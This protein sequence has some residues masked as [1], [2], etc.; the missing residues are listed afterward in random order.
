MNKKPACFNSFLPRNVNKTPE[1]PKKGLFKY[2]LPLF[3]ND[4]TSIF[5]RPKPSNKISFW[6]HLFPLTNTEHVFIP[7]SGEYKNQNNTISY[8]SI[9]ACKCSTPWK[10]NRSKLL[11][12]NS[13]IMEFWKGHFDKMTKRKKRSGFWFWT[14]LLHICNNFTNIVWH[15]SYN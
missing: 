3:L 10:S 15:F 12:G 9:S 7:Y 5:S 1:F 13:E 11:T 14:I 2:I 8:L 6:Q 4:F